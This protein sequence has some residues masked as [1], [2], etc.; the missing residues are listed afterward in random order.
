MLKN[1]VYLQNILTQPL[2]RDDRGVTSVE[3]ALLLTMIGGVL[4]AAVI[5]FGTTLT[6]AF[7]GF[8]F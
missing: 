4:L 2:R 3:Y 6:N 7:K 1:F 5:I 8:A